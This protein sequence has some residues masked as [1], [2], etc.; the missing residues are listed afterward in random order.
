[1]VSHPSLKWAFQ[2]NNVN[3]VSLS[4]QGTLPLYLP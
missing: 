4:K 1:M 2:A 3:L